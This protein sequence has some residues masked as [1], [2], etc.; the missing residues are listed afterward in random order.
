MIASVLEP[1]LS[2]GIPMLLLSKPPHCYL[3]GFSSYHLTYYLRILL[4]TL[5]LLP[6]KF[7]CYYCCLTTIICV[8]RSQLLITLCQGN[9][10]KG[11]LK[12]G[13]IV[14]SATATA[15]LSTSLYIHTWQKPFPWSTTVAVGGI[16]ASTIA[17]T[18]DHCL[19]P[20]TRTSTCRCILLSISTAE[21]WR[22]RGQL[23]I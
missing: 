11:R 13:A 15:N 19:S 8:S 18:T 4:S 9:N 21:R 1:A 17:A 3:V 20:Q 5:L 6:S 22:E 14:P 12:R 16:Q 10:P 23:L 7:E 2:L